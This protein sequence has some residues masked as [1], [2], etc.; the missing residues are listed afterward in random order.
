MQHA[1]EIGAASALISYVYAGILMEPEHLLS[2][3]YRLI[4]RLPWWLSKPLGACN[5]CFAGQLGLWWY[6]LLEHESYCGGW[7]QVIDAGI[8]HILCIC[9]AIFGSKLLNKISSWAN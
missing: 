4:S 1:L 9:V 5:L 3:W 2:G 7:Q 6:L 8:V